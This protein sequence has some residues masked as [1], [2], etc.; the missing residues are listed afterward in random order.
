MHPEVVREGPG[1]CPE[2]GMQLVPASQSEQ[3]ASHARKHEGHSTTMF[4]RKFWVSLILTVPV[5]LYSDLMEALTG[6]TPPSFAGDRYL[7]LV[8]G[9]AIFFIGGWV[10]LASAWRELR[11]RMPGMMTLISL[12]VTAAYAW[13]V[14]AVFT[15][16][17]PLF[18]ELATL[19][20]IMLL[21]H[22]IEMKAV[23]GAK[24]ALRELS[25]LLPS[26]AEVVRDGQTVS[27]PVEDLKIGDVVMVRPGGKIPADG[28]VTAGISH[29]DES[30]VTGE[31]VPARREPGQEVVAGSIN[32]DGSLNVRITK[33][34]KET[35][36][37]EVMRLVEEAQASKSRLQLLS[38]KAAFALTVIAVLGGGTAF[39]AWMLAG[40]GT[41]FAVA[42]LVAVLVI[43]CPH[44]LGLAV[45]L[46]AS[47]S[48]NMASKSG[49]FVKQRL[50]LE[51]A[52]S[53]DTVLFDKTGT[54]TKGTYGVV[55]VWADAAADEREV[56][57][58][59]ASVDAASEHVVARAIV[60][61]ARELGYEIQK[62][63]NFL[64]IPGKGVKG[65]VGEAD[66]YAGGRAILEEAGASPSSHIERTAFAEAA[67]GSTI[68]F[69]VRD[70]TVMGAVALADEIRDES[71]QAIGN[72][73][74]MGVSVAMV[75]GDSEQVASWVAED[76]GIDEYFAH[77]LPAQ[78][79]EKVRELQE[80][81]RNV[82]MVGD[83]I[84]DAPALAQA[85]LGIA[86]GAGTNV[87][88]ESAGIILV[89][90]DPRDIPGII[91]LSRLTYRKMLENLF[92][93]TGYNVAALPLAAGVLAWKG[94]LLQPA[95]A[96]VFMSLSTV[97]VA[98]NAL[99]MRRA[100]LGEK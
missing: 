23:Q 78:K 81:G 38:D 26:A 19:I 87:A 97:I 60:A 9:S 51:S 10:F 74:K 70:G 99:L 90:N 2:C 4:L 43:A 7:G 34:G 17:E 31:S 98:V 11:A 83:G 16:Q 62:A 15:G 18:W 76:L 79:A 24:G 32:G 100:Q 77:V 1:M 71:R 69:V 85:D 29:V 42:R 72:L 25:K 36:L 14:Y 57:M 86:V 88:I 89:R 64:R 95:V 92:W 28:E 39:A 46:V 6:W 56:L 93:A 22:W 41:S 94:V 20:T 68:I 40:A 84:N 5:L 8:L 3:R 12:A 96:A 37:A 13:S 50:A 65:R 67:K 33:T 49:F 80:Q 27:V 73:R 61:R 47:I 54:L 75:T 82:A 45:P 52:R 55:G 44:A 48:T 59:A 58:L 30:L 21:G 63:E 35:F 53:I 91:R 66:V